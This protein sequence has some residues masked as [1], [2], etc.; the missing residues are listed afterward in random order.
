MAILTEKKM[1]NKS[2]DHLIQI[3]VH[4][5][6]IIVSFWLFKDCGAKLNTVFCPTI[7][8]LYK[9]N[10]LLTGIFY[11][12]SKGSYQRFFYFFENDGKKYVLSFWFEKEIVADV[13]SNR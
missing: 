11:I 6:L 2:M 7:N 5:N 1:F 4:F 8:I 13:L 10:Y 9:F 12:S 3:K